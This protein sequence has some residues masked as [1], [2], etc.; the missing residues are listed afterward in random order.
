[1]RR[2]SLLLLHVRSSCHAHFAGQ[3][4]QGAADP[5]NVALAVQ[6]GGFV[7]RAVLDAHH[8]QSGGVKHHSATETGIDFAQVQRGRPHPSRPR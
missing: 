7:S 1:M 6:A 5:A 8:R 3:L 4:D 2:Y